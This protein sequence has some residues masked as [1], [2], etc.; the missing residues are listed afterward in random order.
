MPDLPK[1]LRVPDI[2]VTGYDWYRFGAVQRLGL[3]TIRQDMESWPVP[4][5]L[6]HPAHTMKTPL[7]CCR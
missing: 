3:M 2:S 6:P 7:Q 4:S 1:V 5:N